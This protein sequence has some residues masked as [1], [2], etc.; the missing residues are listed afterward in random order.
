MHFSSVI[1]F[2]LGAAFSPSATAMPAAFADFGC[3][4]KIN[5]INQPIL[6][7]QD[8]LSNS[9]PATAK[10][11][12]PLLDQTQ[13]LISDRFQAKREIF[14]NPHQKD[15][16][17]LN[18]NIAQMLKIVPNTPYANFALINQ[19]QDAQKAVPEMT[20]TCKIISP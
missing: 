7:A 4:G 10:A 11:V 8:A 20:K 14:E 9:D 3:V 15:V 16:D 18:A 13:Q 2:L 17:T 19:I 12:S 1:I 6:N 5:D